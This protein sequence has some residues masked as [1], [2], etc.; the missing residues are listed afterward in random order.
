M[1]NT[2]ISAEGTTNADVEDRP[3]MRQPRAQYIHQYVRGHVTDNKNAESFQEKLLRDSWHQNYD[4]VVQWLDGR[5][6]PTPT[7]VQIA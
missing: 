3:S 6:F 2:C 5:P 1:S 4:I 7:A